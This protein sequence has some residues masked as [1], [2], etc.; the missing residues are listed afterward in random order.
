MLAVNIYKDNLYHNF[1]SQ[2]VRPNDAGFY[3][4]VA[5]NILGETISR[6]DLAGHR[7]NYFEK[8]N[9]DLAGNGL[10]YVG[11]KVDRRSCWT[12]ERN[13]IL[14]SQPLF[15]HLFCNQFTLNFATHPP[16]TLNTFIFKLLSFSAYLEINS[17]PPSQAS[18]IAAY[19]LLGLA[20]TQTH[21]A[22]RS[23]RM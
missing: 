10:D 13:F 9:W 16:L 12:Y 18:P 2:R 14:P 11:K 3:S 1:F 4:C 21:I 23:V 22:N 17:S 8:K 20:L 15:H 6:W 5:G 7:F 19:L